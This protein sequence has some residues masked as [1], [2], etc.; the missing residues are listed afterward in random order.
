MSEETLLSIFVRL[1]DQLESQHVTLR[2][3]FASLEQYGIVILILLLALLASIP[4]FII[5]AF[6]TL[7][8]VPMVVLIVQLI[9]DM[10]KLALPP[11]AMDKQIP[12]KPL[13][14]AIDFL[15]PWVA[16]IESVSRHRLVFI[17]D[18][19]T[20]RRIAGVAALI[21]ALA[22]F[23]PFPF[24]NIVPAICIAAI[25]AGLLLRD[26]LIVLM[27]GIIGLGWITALFTIVLTIGVGGLQWLLHH[28]IFWTS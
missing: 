9:L 16:R 11:A 21:M 3:V 5:P 26:G 14:A 19:T 20:S 10:P 17:A 22:V 18:N 12:A 24:T 27:G 4:L 2:E 15:L 25:A 8:S 13:R 23:I 6:H 7:I 1:R 28:M